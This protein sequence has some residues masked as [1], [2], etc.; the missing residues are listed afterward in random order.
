V[1]RYGYLLRVPL[2]TRSIAEIVKKYA[3]RIGLRR[4]I[5]LDLQELRHT[6]RDEGRRHP[7]QC[8]SRFFQLKIGSFASIGD[9]T[10]RRSLRASTR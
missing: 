2:S 6:H 9:N 4:P 5:A 1:P 8:R 3:R 7:S 10:A